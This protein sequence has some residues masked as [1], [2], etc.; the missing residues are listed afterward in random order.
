[1]ALWRKCFSRDELYRKITILNDGINAKAHLTN[2]FHC[3]YVLINTLR[4]RYRHGRPSQNFARVRHNVFGPTDNNWPVCLLILT[5]ISKI[6]ASRCQE[7]KAK[8]HQ[9]CFPAL[10]GQLTALF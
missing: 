10:L 3:M 7:F 1:M 2:T 4:S 5:K 6:D 8:M 9:I